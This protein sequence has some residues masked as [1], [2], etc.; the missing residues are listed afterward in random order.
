MD[1]SLVFQKVGIAL[2]L[3]LLVGR[4]REHAQRV[5]IE[6]A[7]V[8]P[9]VFGQTAPPLAVMLAWMAFV[10]TLLSYFSRGERMELP[11]RRTPRGCTFSKATTLSRS[12]IRRRCSQSRPA[13]RESWC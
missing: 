5:L 1:E 8:A 4:Q 2:G 11:P 10:C 6:I 3:G 7:V 9:G 12:S 13:R